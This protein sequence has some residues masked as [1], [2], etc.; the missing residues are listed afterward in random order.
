MGDGEEPGCGR[1]RKIS[2]GGRFISDGHQEP[3]RSHRRSEAP[4]V[5]FSRSSAPPSPPADRAAINPAAEERQA[6]GQAE[7]WK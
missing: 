7:G 5:S 3:R 2:D 4:A 1:E 6:G